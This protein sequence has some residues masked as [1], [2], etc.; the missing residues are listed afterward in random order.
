MIV[1]VNFAAYAFNGGLS[2][3]VI[4]VGIDAHIHE[5]SW[6][7]AGWRHNDLN[8]ASGAP[9]AAQNTLGTLCP[10]ASYAFE[11]QGTL[12]VFYLAADGHIHEL[13]RDS[14]GWHNNDL[15]VA[16]GSPLLEIGFPTQITFVGYPFEAQS[17]QHVFFCVQNGLSQSNHV[18]ELR[19]ADQAWSVVDA[20]AQASGPI[21]GGRLT[22]HA[23]PA[24]G[25]L[26]VFYTN[27]TVHELW[28]DSEGW[29]DHAINPTSG[30]T[31]Q[32]SYVDA[33]EGT[34]HVLCWTN[35]V[36]GLDA[37]FELWWGSDGWHL[38]NLSTETGAPGPINPPAGY[39]FDAQGTQHAAYYQNPSLSGNG[40][41]YQLWRDSA[42]WHYDDLTA[43]TGAP[44]AVNGIS[45]FPQGYVFAAQST[46]HIVYLAENNHLIE[47]YW[48][49]E[50]FPS[51]V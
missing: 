2:Q 27:G 33:A 30:L 11:T 6:S 8:L 36:E 5:L 43:A 50:T 1:T 37:L 29:H 49:P 51:P 10:L 35:A 45:V 38:Q 44:V 18:I 41:V 21:A 34:Q 9:L 14:G 25:T 24:Q 12:H 16:V 48:A 22:G 39:M 19:W 20:T 40:H 31:P 42:G 26:H 32:S 13:W 17:T 23:F 7:S 15:T 4:F 3:H 47:L 46:Q 28:W